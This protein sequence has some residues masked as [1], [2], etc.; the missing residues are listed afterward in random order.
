MR[1]DNDV[2]LDCG[3]LCQKQSQNQSYLTTQISGFSRS[4]SSSI[5]RNL[6][7]A[8]L[9]VVCAPA[10]LDPLMAQLIEKRVETAAEALVMPPL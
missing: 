3:R 5:L 1:R 8:A 10:G 7:A 6:S 2:G 4:L 9:N